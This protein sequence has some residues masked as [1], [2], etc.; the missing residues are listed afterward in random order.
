[1]AGS[2]WAP[3]T[4][5]KHRLRRQ[6]SWHAHSLVHSACKCLPFSGTPGPC[7]P[8]SRAGAPT[9]LL[10]TRRVLNRTKSEQRKAFRDS[11]DSW[12]KGTL[13]LTWVPAEGFEEGGGPRVKQKPPCAKTARRAEGMRPLGDCVCSSTLIDSSLRV[14]GS[15]HHSRRSPMPQANEDHI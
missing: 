13:C 15:D 14:R 4:W 2:R 3:G 7:P 10:R 6:E 1:M 8:H 11:W 12:H 5:A 9:R